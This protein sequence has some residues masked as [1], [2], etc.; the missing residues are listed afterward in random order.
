MFGKLRSFRLLFI[1]LLIVS[2]LILGSCA[3]QSEIPES[4]HPESEDDS[5]PTEDTNVQSESTATTE[6]TTSNEDT[7]APED[8]KQAS[9]PPGSIALFSTVSGG[10]NSDSLKLPGLNLSWDSNTYKFLRYVPDVNMLDELDWTTSKS[11]AKSY[12]YGFTSGEW[13][14]TVRR[15]SDTD[16]NDITRLDP[17][18]GKTVGQFPSITV[19]G[20]WKF[21][22]TVLGDRLIY[23]TKINETLSGSRRSGGDVMAVEIGG[24]PIKILDYADPNNIGNYYAIGDKLITIVRTSKDN[25]KAYDIYLVNPENMVIGDHLYTYVS[26]DLVTFYEGET[27]LYWSQTDSE[28]G[29]INIIRFPLSDEP[30]FYLIISGDNPQLISVDDSQGMILI[31][32]SDDIPDRHFFYSLVDI[33]TGTITEYELDK[34]FFKGLKNGN[35]QFFILE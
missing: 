26:D 12:I 14:Y 11:Y 33:A 8:N 31:M 4:L 32:Y 18:T 16:R 15:S 5:T 24:S 17:R 29:D 1:T 21:G 13:V 22:F 3:T 6:T 30:S 10:I 25:L 35:G 19:T 34:A 9:I 28:T 20:D 2:I 23:R 7:T 27:A